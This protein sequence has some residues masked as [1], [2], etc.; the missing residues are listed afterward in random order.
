MNKIPVFFMPE[1]V[2]DSKSF[3]PSAGKPGLVVEAWKDYG[4][5]IE[6][7]PFQPCSVDDIALAHDRDFIEDI[8]SG[9]RNN[10]HGNRDAGVAKSLPYTTGSMVAAVNAALSNGVGAVSPTSGF[11]HAGT[12]FVGGFCTF[13][14]LMIAAA[15]SKASRIGILDLDYHYGDGTDEIIKRLGLDRRIRHYSQGRW[16]D[17]PPA[18]WLRSL[19]KTVRQQFAHCD[20]VIYQAGQDPHVDDPLGGWLTTDQLLMRDAIVFDTLHDLGVPVAWNLAGG[21]QEDFSKVI[22]GHVNTMAAFSDIFFRG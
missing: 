8:L 5:P 13:N 15:Q 10:G 18:K 11:H 4:L 21:Y 6:V 9:R 16:G 12:D 22:K 2:A 14:G 1:M 7:L 19:S 3:S 17:S 20:V